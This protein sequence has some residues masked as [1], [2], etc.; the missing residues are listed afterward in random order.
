MSLYSI[1][2]RRPVL[3]VVMSITIVLF[4]M[5]GFFDLGVREY[6]AVDP[7][8]ITVATNYR[9]ANADV[10][11]SQITEPIEESVNGISGI[12]TLTSV[13]REGRSTVTVEFDIDVDLERAANDVRDRVSRAVGNLP[14][15]ADPPIVTKADADA[16]PIVFL[17]V[18]SDQRNLLELTKI[19]DDIFKERLQTI[20]GVSSIDIWG[21]K[22]YA[23]RLW[24]DPQK[25]AA[26][27][28]SPL[29]V[30]NAITRENVELPSGRI[31]GRDVELTVRTMSRLETPDA[32][33]NLIIKDDG[34][35]IVRL[36]DIGRAELG[37]LNERTILKR[38]G[39]PMVGV[40][41]RPLPGANNIAII[42]E[43]YRRVDQIERELSDDIEL[44]IG[45]DNTIYIR[46]SV[47]EVQQTIFVALALVVL[48]IFLFLRDWRTTIIPAVVI[49]ISLIG[50]F[51]IMY[52]LDFSINV[53]TM[54]GIVLAIGM[55]VDDAIVV[56]ENIY[57][58]I[59]AGMPP[60]EAGIEGTREIFVAVIATTL[61]LVAVFLPILFLGGL[62]GRLFREFGMVIG[63]SVVISSFVA[64]TLTPMLSSRLL[65]ARTKHSWFYNKTEPFFEWMTR[66]YRNTLDTFMQ[67]R[68]LAFPVLVISF[69][70]IPFFF[71]SLP[72]EL[73][74]L[75][76]R[77][78]LRLVATA[79]E[80]ATFEYMDAYVDQLTGLA[81]EQVPETA[82]IFS[83]TSPG[84]GAASSVNSGFLTLTLTEAA[85]RER[86]QQEIAD[87][88]VAQVQGLTGARTFVSQP[89]TIGSRTFGLPLQF[90]IQAPSFEK[91][92]EIL[93]A[94]LEEARQDPTFTFTDVDLKF[95]KPE[96]RI[97]IN[98]ERA[99]AL[100]VSALDI[101]QTLQ[102]AL[103]EQRLGYFIMDGKQY[104]VIG[105]V[106]RENRDETL[107]LRSLFVRNAAGEP[108]QL[109]NLV[110]VN[111]E[112]SPPALY[113]FN[114][115]VSAT[116]SA[117]MA[118]GKTMG[119]GIEAMRAIAGRVL[120][121]TFSTDLSGPSRDFVESSSSLLFVFL[122]ALALIYL[123]LA[124]QFESFRDPFTIMLTV[125][126]ALAGALFWLWYFDQTLNIF[127][128]IG[129]IMLIGLVTKNGI[130]IVEF[131]NQR[132]Q[133][134][135]SIAEAANDA[136]VT[137]L[138]P[139]LMTSISTILGILPIALALGAGAES[140]VPMGIAVIGGLLIGTF[141]TL[142]VI[143]AMYTY[144]ASRT[145]NRPDE[146]KAVVDALRTQGRAPARTEKRT[147]SAPTAT[148]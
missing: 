47:S 57:T 65:K 24:L 69:A 89:E 131:A 59:E 29:D 98:R 79:P 78:S 18:K 108:V 13:S 136:A 128:E 33:N 22:V 74:P 109:D 84:F 141:L 51:F 60:L 134:G 61:A 88:L 21:S 62:T 90:V 125:P 116:V 11:E 42:D 111:E 70:A 123:V 117:S 58:K 48:I 4:G 119:D 113:R 64:L 49:P 135:L 39:I 67:Y 142:Y 92:T 130:L 45:F 17:S 100:G 146:L 120:D 54:L 138:R 95:N 34:G 101:A 73:A 103:S 44:G 41:L 76:D 9:G 55:V 140:R 31:E 50:A 81:R 6:P 35:Q 145:V 3:A 20:E 43:F 1:S 23:M 32:F 118:P 75:E 27:K 137:R 36:M 122:L 66:S 63:G 105:Q 132:R 28:L 7:P 77:N 104:Q 8:I 147:E 133:Q 114:R 144:L 148:P 72:A 143:P 14:P 16:F 139:V 85:E 87:L 127:S 112:S 129:M 37:P 93:P 82:S 40:V 107:D 25:L 99:R 121:D 97:S 102:L 115:F 80:G 2:I 52:M 30:R 110:E 53:L 10:I 124:A 5:L 26:Y 91:L 12:R 38:D 94:F 83:V 46:E 106:E 86:S 19:A 56:L 96:L 15:D 68:W 126:L 71:S